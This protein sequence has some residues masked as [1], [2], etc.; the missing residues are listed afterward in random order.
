[1]RRWLLWL[2]DNVSLGK[3]APWV[4]GLA[5][6]RR[7][8]RVYDPVVHTHERM[9]ASGEEEWRVTMERERQQR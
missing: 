7:P 3:L 6:G 1:M 8:H 2:V 9:S 4:W 5:L